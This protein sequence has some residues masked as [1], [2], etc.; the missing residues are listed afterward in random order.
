MS[1]YGL[2]TIGFPSEIKIGV[3]KISTTDIW[4]SLLLGWKDF[5]QQPSHYFFTAILYPFMGF[6]LYFWAAGEN[7]LQLLFPML[8]GLALLGP[9]VSLPLY[10]I[11][12]RLEKGLD[13]S[14]AEVFNVI[15]SSALPAILILGL[16]LL[17][18]FCAW[19]FTANILYVLLYGNEYPVSIFNFLREVISTQRGWTLIVVGNGLGFCFALLAFCTTVVAFPLVLEHEV[20]ALYGIKASVQAVKVNPIPMILWGLV[21]SFGLLLASIVVLVGLILVL[22][23][24]AHATWHIYRKV[25][26]FPNQHSL[27]PGDH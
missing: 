22:P 21:I 14:W 7:T 4:Q 1:Q 11:S 17:V 13:T 6:A 15:K 18:I 20:S 10:E 5:L 23:V 24:F 19:I 27:N 8:T 25:L 2:I 16:M 12:R 3:N 26:V 9:F